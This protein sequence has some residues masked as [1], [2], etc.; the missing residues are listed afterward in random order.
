MEPALWTAVDAY[1][2][3]RLLPSD[4]ALDA[5]LAAN[6]A[7]GLPAID[8][9]ATQ[10]KL[11][12]LLARLHGA[13]TILEVGTLGGYSTICL[14]R[15]LPPVGRLLTLE[16]D[17]KHAEVARANVDRAG[18]GDK[19]EIRVGPASE[20]LKSLEDPYDM[21]FVDADKPSNPTYWREALRLTKKGSLIIVD[22]VVR[23]GG[24]I[25]NLEDPGVQGVRQM[26]DLIATESR[27]EATAV[28]T[29]G[30]KGYDG[31]LVALVV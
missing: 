31:F 2:A 11:L 25:D 8:V 10:G 1:L 5:A 6:A 23:N 16:L 22:N 26:M 14:A 21:V 9:S 27:I 28:Q 4:P 30:A 3:D 19:V 24:V 20:T 29:V 18:I 12:N 13:K 7:A 17:P 15:A